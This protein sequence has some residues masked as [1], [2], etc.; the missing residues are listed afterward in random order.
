PGGRP[1]GGPFGWPVCAG[2]RIRGSW[3]VLSVG[4]QWGADLA[5]EPAVGVLAQ[6]H[7]H[8]ELAGRG[9]TLGAET[10]DG[11][12]D[13]GDGFGTGLVGRGE[14]A[15]DGAHGGDHLSLHEDIA[16]IPT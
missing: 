7:R 2:G 11:L 13:D 8:R 1:R 12:V 16:Q 6:R 15:L 4:E 9:G 14:R 3:E 5:D 10:G